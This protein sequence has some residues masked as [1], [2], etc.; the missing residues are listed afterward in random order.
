MV[1]GIC[2]NGGWG[3]VWEVMVLVYVRLGFILAWV[4]FYFVRVF[5]GG[6]YE[7]LG[8]GVS[9]VW[10]VVVCCEVGGR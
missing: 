7:L 8:E 5:R 10:D 4:G 6:I 3:Y 9:L 1:L 2:C